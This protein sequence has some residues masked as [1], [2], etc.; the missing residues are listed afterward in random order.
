[1]KAFALPCFLLSFFLLFSPGPSFAYFETMNNADVVPVG[2]L[3]MIGSSQAIFDRHEGLN[4][5]ALADVGLSPNSD[6]RMTFGLGE[7]DFSFGGFYKWAPI[8][9]IENQPAIGAIFGVTYG[10]IDGSNEFTALVTPI[11]SKKY[12]TRH[13]LF[14]PHIGLPLGIMSRSGAD[15]FPINLV[16]GTEWLPVHFKWANAKLMIEIGFDL[17]QSITYGTLGLSFTFDNI[18]YLQIE[19]APRE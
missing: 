15:K 9:D 2:T 16:A 8:P 17:N 3:R 7:V 6:I 18:S 5:S 19:Q 1:M 12:D 10:H 13:G 4:V 11:L 14:N